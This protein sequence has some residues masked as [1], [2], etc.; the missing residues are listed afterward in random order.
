MSGPVIER[1]RPPPI[2]LSAAVVFHALPYCEAASRRAG[3][4][5][6]ARGLR[7]RRPNPFVFPFNGAHFTEREYV[8]TGFHGDQGVQQHGFDFGVRLWRDDD[9][10]EPSFEEGRW[11]ELNGNVSQSLWES[12]PAHHHFRIYGRPVRAMADGEVV[13]CWRNA[14]ENPR[15]FSAA[16]GDS[17]T[18]DGQPVRDDGSNVTPCEDSAWLDPM[19]CE[20]R[21][22]GGGN[23]LWIRHDSGS[24]ALYAHFKPDTIPEWL[25]PHDEPLFSQPAR[26][27]SSPDIAT[28]AAVSDGVRVAAGDYLGEVGN[29][30]ASSAPHLHVHVEKDGRARPIPFE[31]GLSAPFRWPTSL[32]DA[33]R[34]AR[35]SS[36]A[37]TTVPR[38]AGTSALIWPPRSTSLP[39][40]RVGVPASRLQSWME[41]LDDSGY[42]PG[43][44]TCAVEAGQ[45][46][47]DLIDWQPPAFETDWY[48]RFG[49]GNDAL[50]GE[51]ERA[52]SHG[53]AV[54]S[55][56]TCNTATLENSVVAFTR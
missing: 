46:S 31:R 19:L 39:F 24:H 4:Q 29:S 16:L 35:L 34:D 41:H 8:L 43:L 3:P 10:V 14:P 36:F 21:M 55:V 2:A 15:P 9:G 52:E 40:E 23:H 22:A 47:Y 11:S 50:A 1:C 33:T 5:Q 18:I 54:T 51:I 17:W 38:D 30:G 25:C 32:T 49:L 48:M 20:R 28:E 12:T 42:T 37:G 26:G 45:V 6:R 7:R 13:G 56:F 53:H 27:R 44:V